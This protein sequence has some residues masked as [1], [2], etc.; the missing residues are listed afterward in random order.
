MTLIEGFLLFMSSQDELTGPVNIGNPNEFTIRQLA[1][2]TI[3]LTKSSSSLIYQQLPCDDPLQ[4]QPNIDLAKTKLG[5]MPDVQ[6][7]EGLT[8]TI[9]YFKRFLE[10]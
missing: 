5:W 8:K 4:R 7:E 3:E 9:D 1:E 10:G 6:L 2:K